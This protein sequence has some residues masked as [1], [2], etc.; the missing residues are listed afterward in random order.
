[1]FSDKQL[2]S[3]SFKKKQAN[4]KARDD[5]P[6]LTFAEVKAGLNQSVVSEIFHKYAPAINPDNKVQKINNQM[7]AGS[8][9]MSINGDKTG[10]WHRFSSGDKG[11]IF[12]F[13]EYATSCSKHEAL[14]IV[15]SM[16]G[17]TPAS[18]TK[19]AANKQITAKENT[20]TEKTNNHLQQKQDSW[21]P[22]SI[23]AS[24]PVF[25][26]T[27]HLSFLI[28]KGNVITLTHQYKNK[29]SQ[30][31][32][33]AVRI[34]DTEGKKQVLPVAYCYNEAKGQGRWQLKGFSDSGTKPIYGVE[35]IAHNPEKPILIVEGEK[36]ADAASKLMPNHNV[37]SWMGGAQAVGKV[38]WQKLNNKL[39][40]IWPDNDQAGIRAA[41]NIRNHIDCHNGF[42]GLVSIVDTEK[43]GLP[44]K[45]DLA[46][47]MP[48]K[49]DSN[50][51]SNHKITKVNLNEIIDDA[52]ENTTSIGKQLE[53]SQITTN[54]SSN[55]KILDSIDM[56]VA[57]NRISGDKYL[58]K[59]MYQHT[60]LAI[61]NTKNIN[62]KAIDNPK[63][64]AEAISNIQDEYQSLHRDYEQNILLKKNIASSISGNN[65]S[66]LSNNEQ[67]SHDLIR[68]TSVLHQAQLD[69]KKLPQAH[70]QNIEKAVN[71]EIGKMQR[72]TDSDKEHAANNI[73][74]S[75]DSKKWQ[76]QL[77]AQNQ[78]KSSDISLRFSAKN[79]DAFLGS[80]HQ[81]EKSHLEQIRKYGID[82]SDALKAFRGGH[83]DGAKELAALN[84]KIVIAHGHLEQNKPIFDLAGAHNSIA[85]S[86][87]VMQDLLG[88]NNKVAEKNCLSAVLNQFNQQKHDA[89]DTDSIFNIIKAEDQ[90]L[91]KVQ[92]Q[93]EGH[94]DDKLQARVNLS[95]TAKSQ[96]FI[97]N[98][99]DNLE[100]NR[101]QGV[102]SNEDL[103]KLLLASG[104]DIKAIFSQLS[105]LTQDNQRRGLFAMR[106]ELDELH[107]LGFYPDQNKL[108]ADLKSISYTDKVS[109]GKKLLGA[110]T[111]KYLEPILN[112]CAKDREVANNS[113]QLLKAIINEQKVHVDLYDNHRTAV[114]AWDKINDNYRH[115]LIIK[116]AN[117]I[118]G[119]YTP[120]E[121]K[122]TVTYGL[123]NNLTSIKAIKNELHVNGGNFKNVFN[124]LK[125]DCDHHQIKFSNNKSKSIHSKDHEHETQM[126]QTKVTKIDKD[127]SM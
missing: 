120:K 65:N 103:S 34:E 119:K 57:T 83:L 46:D 108:V 89:K 115:S 26:P 55:A 31:L 4:I 78:E 1:M 124:P 105:K 111:K 113:E 97:A 30:L 126:S 96:E 59:D 118:Y 7:K 43:L 53:S 10:L 116:A 125:L 72:F 32:G 81:Q 62:L 18:K 112:K 37:I 127:F 70:S 40:T 41:N 99:K 8:L 109:Y 2:S 87:Q 98:I 25:N 76:T 102:V 12:S 16:A 117:D 47:E 67:L 33:Y 36:T 48:S 52:R 82:E 106:N 77:D 27:K 20:G 19:I 85:G 22:I 110:K 58:S 74:K 51:S 80:N 14:G 121:I 38:D 123:K 64:F 63:D 71:S 3:K 35:K 29:D 95:K 93:H 45:W 86:N 60:I 68:D 94:L 101:K 17:I 11:D 6:R 49:L 88:V 23:D 66:K 21:E 92:L 61:A 75:V 100:A 9:Y 5:K 39:I 107:K 28:Q 50:N 90:F 56:L 91:T 69:Q 84:K 104:H 79:I 24:A 54:I 44:A 114:R 15:A 73:F 122:E 42:S 13:V